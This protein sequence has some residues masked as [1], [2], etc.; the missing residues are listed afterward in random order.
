M[1]EENQV[2]ITNK[3]IIE[4]AYGRTDSKP[5]IVIVVKPGNKYDLQISGITAIVPEVPSVYPNY[6]FKVGDA[7]IVECPLGSEH[8]RQIVA[9]STFAIPEESIYEFSTKPK[10]R[11]K[12]GVSIVIRSG[13][14]FYIHTLD[15]EEGVPPVVYD[16]PGVGDMCIDT[17]GH[18]LIPDWNQLYRYT[19]ETGLTDSIE[20]DEGYFSSCCMNKA[21][22]N[23]Y[24][25]NDHYWMYGSIFR[26][27]PEM[28]VLTFISSLTVPLD[29]IQFIA[30]DGTYTYVFGYVWISEPYTSYYKNI[31]QVYNYDGTFHSS[32]FW[33]EG[34]PSFNTMKIFG[35]E[36][37]EVYNIFYSDQTWEGAN[38][39]IQKYLVSDFS[40][41]VLSF[42]LG[43]M[44]VVQDVVYYDNNIYVIEDYA[45]GDCV[46]HVWKLA[47]YSAS[48][49]LIK[50]VDLSELNEWN[51][52][53][54]IDYTNKT[55]IEDGGGGGIP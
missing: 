42:S 40:E 43:H 1:S 16:T 12:A 23:M 52:A 28:S 15:L 9:P 29:S 21:N 19:I 50:R 33:L 3:L 14:N 39:T 20:L 24:F 36:P 5:G 31:I 49:S 6:V 18:C 30:S 41:P 44:H 51:S 54:F 4:Q 34:E 7:V 32:Y 45:E 53:V 11:P 2:A 37:G 27:T 25:H 55:F 26:V 46:P 22:N 38:Y 17:L 48:G 47:K 8:M 35:G 10:E 13:Y